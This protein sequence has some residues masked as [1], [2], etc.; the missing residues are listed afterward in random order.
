EL[1]DL[2][3]AQ[4]YGDIISPSDGTLYLRI[5]ADIRTG[6]NAS[7][8]SAS[9]NLAFSVSTPQLSDVGVVVLDNPI[10]TTQDLQ[11]I[12]PPLLV[13]AFSGIGD[14]FGGFPIPQFFG[15]QPTVVQVG[16]AG[17]FLAVY[18]RL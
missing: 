10:G 6:F 15:I 7:F 4:M 1:G 3:I 16:K 11:S 9:G 2:R 13:Q 14:A 12:L 18:L 5:A 8:D 17:S